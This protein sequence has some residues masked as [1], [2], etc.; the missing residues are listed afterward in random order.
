M[1]F[2]SPKWKQTISSTEE[3]KIYSMT[4]RNLLHSLKWHS[5]Q[6]QVCAPQWGVGLNSFHRC[7]FLFCS[8]IPQVRDKKKKITDFSSWKQ[9]L[10]HENITAHLLHIPDF[11]PLL[12]SLLFFQTLN[13][14]P[15]SVVNRARWRIQMEQGSEINTCSTLPLVAILRITLFDEP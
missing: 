13:I 8:W 3:K 7:I 12:F 6:N 5:I 1:F 10:C 4:R 14:K 11:G 9:G 15:T 2:F